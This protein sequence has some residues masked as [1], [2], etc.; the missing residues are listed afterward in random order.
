MPQ[1]EVPDRRPLLYAVVGVIILG[2]AAVL[3]WP[4]GHEQPPS[5]LVL[6]PESVRQATS[7]E[8]PLE[9]SDGQ[10]TPADA[11]AVV[12]EQVPADPFTVEDAT[13]PDTTPA[14]PDDGRTGATTP[15]SSAK[16][17]VSSPPLSTRTPGISG[18]TSAGSY[19]IYVGSYRDEDNARRAAQRL[20]SEG[21]QA[22]V[23]AAGGLHRVRIGFFATSDAAEA[24]GTTVKRRFGLDYWVSRR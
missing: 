12:D 1:A 11:S 10:E 21:V 13:L 14:R 16:A 19:Q 24:Y 18:P 8:T 20:I 23:V 17:E 3:F 9:E 5:S 2:I 15:P 7:L 22:E 4:D 6:T